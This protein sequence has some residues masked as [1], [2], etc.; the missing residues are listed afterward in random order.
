MTDVVI[1]QRT[2]YSLS[3]DWSNVISADIQYRITYAPLEGALFPNEDSAQVLSSNQV[4]ESQIVAKSL[5]PGKEYV[6]TISPVS[7]DP[8]SFEQVGQSQTVVTY[9]RKFFLYSICLHL[10]E[11][12]DMVYVFLLKTFNIAAI[13]T[14]FPCY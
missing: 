3:L 4:S 6:F 13:I 9:T 7:G 2:P 8:S 5:A 14:W 11:G 1:T 12:V 10:C